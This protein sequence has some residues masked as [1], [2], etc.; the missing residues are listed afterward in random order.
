MTERNSLVDSQELLKTARLKKFR[1]LGVARVLMNVLRLNK[2][3]KL[4]DEVSETEGLGFINE[5]ID[6]LEIDFE[7]R[8]KEIQRIPKEGAFITVSNHPY[9]GIDG[10]LLVKI[11]SDI[12]PDIRVMAN[13]L[14]NRIQPASEFMFPVNPFENQKDKSSS[15]K[16]I[17]MAIQHLKEGGVLGI[18]PAG[19]VSSYNPDNLGKTDRRWQTPALKIIKNAKVPVVPVYFEGTNSRFFHM[20]GLIHPTLRTARLPSEVLN[21]RNASA[22][23]IPFLL[24]SRM[25]FRIWSALADTSGPGPMPWDL[26][27]K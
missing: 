9:G 17:K 21:K 5:L 27:W 26:R 11:I 10:L 16:G 23:E 7:I 3:N 6:K 18:F 8:E 13:F 24:L 4:F 2:L 25:N 12:R 1:R 15:L 20:L 22:S 14:I 19:E